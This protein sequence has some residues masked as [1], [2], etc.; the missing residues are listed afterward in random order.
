MGIQPILF[1]FCFINWAFIS[2]IGFGI[3]KQLALDG[4]KVI[5][6][7]RKQDKVINAV[8]KLEK[9]QGCTVKGIVCHVGKS[10][11]RKNLIKEVHFSEVLEM[12]ICEYIV[13]A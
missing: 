7:S 4:A 11:H 8:A 13:R 3:A 12:L 2:R 6:S 9:E 5:V 1:F 10:E